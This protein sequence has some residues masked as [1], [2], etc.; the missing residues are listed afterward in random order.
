MPEGLVCKEK[1]EG[2]KLVSRLCIKGDIFFLKQDFPRPQ[3]GL[4]EIESCE[5]CPVFPPPTGQG[6]SKDEIKN[7]IEDTLKVRRF[8]KDLIRGIIE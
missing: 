2:G 3:Y 7:L 6:V 5:Q 4:S 1:Y 8:L